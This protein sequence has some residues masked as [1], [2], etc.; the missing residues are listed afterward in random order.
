MFDDELLGL[1][2][3]I[4]LDENAAPTRT[5]SRGFSLE[6]AVRASASHRLANMFYRVTV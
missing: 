4:F 5:F 1:V 6:I 3:K 2:T